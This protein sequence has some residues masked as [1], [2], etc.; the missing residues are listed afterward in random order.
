MQWKLNACLNI[1]KLNYAR[2]ILLLLTILK[3]S[4]SLRILTDY[5][6]IIF[7]FVF[8]FIEATI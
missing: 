2:L 8:F 4:K 6:D 3:L 1:T 5:M 7:Y